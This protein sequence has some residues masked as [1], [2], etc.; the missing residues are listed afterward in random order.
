MSAMLKYQQFEDSKCDNLETELR[1]SKC[2]QLNWHDNEERQG[3]NK[4]ESEP[5]GEKYI[6]FP[7]LASSSLPQRELNRLTN[8]SRG[9]RS[10]N[11][12]VCIPK[13]CHLE[14]R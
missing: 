5:E 2:Q 3:L 8:L 9:A 10:L 4:Y 6:F 13:I 14:K 1:V 12:F 11:D 7:F